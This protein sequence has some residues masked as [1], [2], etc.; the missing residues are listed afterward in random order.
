MGERDRYTKCL[1]DTGNNALQE[2]KLDYNGTVTNIGFL[3]MIHQTPAGRN[4]DMTGENF[5][6]TLNIFERWPTCKFLQ[7]H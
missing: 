3:I 6:W 5:S 7:R 2:I 1:N 4:L